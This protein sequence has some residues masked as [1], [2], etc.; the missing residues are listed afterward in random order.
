[1]KLKVIAFYSFF[2]GISVIGMWAMILLTGNIAEGKTEISYH[3][4][5]EFMMAVVCICAGVTILQGKKL[6][7]SLALIGHG[8]VIYSVLNAAG[9]YGQRGQTGMTVMFIGLLVISFLVIIMI[10]S[11]RK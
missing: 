2:L 8:M 10:F 4:I 6:G 7:P 1:M 11:S 9:Y 3:L 5:S